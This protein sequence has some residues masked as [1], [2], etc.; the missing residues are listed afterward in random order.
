MKNHIPVGPLLVQPCEVRAA[1]FKTGGN[2]TDVRHLV[3]H[4][5]SDGCWQVI[6]Q[7]EL[8]GLSRQARQQ[9]IS[10][11]S[12]IVSGIDAEGPTITALSGSEELAFVGLWEAEHEGQPCC[13]GADF[14]ESE[15]RCC[16][17]NQF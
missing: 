10:M 12:A 3:I 14:S 7:H 4:R 11:A 17:E 13:C 2:D 5:A 9:A 16:R 15:Q 1:G 6:D 8:C